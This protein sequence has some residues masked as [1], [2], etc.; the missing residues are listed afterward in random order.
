MKRIIIGEGTYGCVHKPSIPCK[1]PPS[2][3]FNY[4][5]YVSKIMKTKNAED[6]LAEFVIIQKID[7]NNEYHLG[8]P[9]LCKPELDD[10]IK[11]DI[12]RCSN[13]K[14]DEVN[15]P[16]DY[17]LLLLKFG[18][19]D[20]KQ[21]G[22]KYMSKYLE[23]DKQKR[24]D[25]FWLEVHH[26]IKGLILFK[27]YGL[28]HYDIKPHNILFDPR[29]GKLKYIDFGLMREKKE[30][31]SLSKE[32][33]NK[34]GGYHWSYPLDCNL[35]NYKKFNNYKNLNSTNKE[36]Y[37]DIFTKLV[38]SPDDTQ[39]I[40]PSFDLKISKPEQ[41]KILFTY[42]NPEN[43]EPSIFTQAGYITS[44]FNGINNMI[45]T[46]TYNTILNFTIDSIDIYGLGFSLQFIA[47]YFKRN[48][49]LTLSEFTNLSMFLNK[50]YDFNPET[51]VNNLND[52][53][54][55]YEIVLFENGVLG[56][57]GKSFENNNLVN[58]PPLPTSIMKE[59]IKE[60]KLTPKQLSPELQNFANLDVT[61]V[62]SRCAE[63]KEINPITKRCVKKCS[64]GFERN[65]KFRCVK[66]KKVRSSK[67]NSS[68]SKSMKSKSM[69]SKSMKSNSIKNNLYKRCPEEKELNPKT[70]RCVKRCIPGYSRNSNFKCR[71]HI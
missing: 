42:L 70:N 55:E 44:Y 39:I 19:F 1:T 16:D 66:T 32:N 36:K 38:V 52:L 20:L 25:E 17:S 37:L 63:D 67:S 29:N 62:V 22:S 65:S 41:F 61:E 5:N 3:G 71:K 45:K 14:I 4:S 34:M 50:M 35:M 30:I 24:T 11:N 6:E 33:R 28:V 26:L 8:E 12:S 69:K 64:P 9:I 31:V 58:K 47:N 48:N 68:K 43:V 2:P 60:E 10:N 15:N 49:A 57:L 18:G 54:N 13:I 40:P 53:L 59:A 27:K 21:F 46:K 51:R 56:R 7:P 23:N